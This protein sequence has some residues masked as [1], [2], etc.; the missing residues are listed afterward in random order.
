[1]SARHFLKG[2]LAEGSLKAGSGASQQLGPPTLLHPTQLLSWAQTHQPAR[3]GFHH[4]GL[5]QYCYGWVVLWTV[6]YSP[7]PPQTVAT[8]SLFHCVYFTHYQ[9]FCLLI[10]TMVTIITL[11]FCV[12]QSWYKVIPIL[13]FVTQQ[14]TVRYTLDQSCTVANLHNHTWWPSWYFLITLPAVAHEILTTSL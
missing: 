6:L 3:P 12:C 5:A 14:G 1:M 10:N 9:G 13:N 8:F 2:R 11:L 4:S 7:T